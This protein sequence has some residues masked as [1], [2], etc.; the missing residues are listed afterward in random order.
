MQN[1]VQRNQGANPQELA[2]AMRKMEECLQV[3]AQLSG[4][5]SPSPQKMMQ[6][7]NQTQQQ[8]QQQQQEPQQRVLSPSNPSRLVSVCYRIKETGHGA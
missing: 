7:A 4:A 1:A 3:F 6:A 8:Q 5:P 2:T